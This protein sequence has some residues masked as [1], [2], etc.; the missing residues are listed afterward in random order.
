MLGGYHVVCLKSYLRFFSF[1]IKWSTWSDCS[2]FCGRGMKKRV[3]MCALSP[4]LSDANQL[5]R[6][7]DLGLRKQDFEHIEDCN[8]WNK[9]K[10]PR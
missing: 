10:C 4:T 3:T 2:S 8:T 9:N 5:K 6:C 7:R 1:V